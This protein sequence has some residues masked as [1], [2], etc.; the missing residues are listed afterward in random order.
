[1]K[2]LSHGA[3]CEE[4]ISERWRRRVNEREPF[5]FL[6]SSAIWNNVGLNGSKVKACLLL[7]MCL[8]VLPRHRRRF[9]HDVTCNFR[10]DAA[11]LVDVSA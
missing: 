10:L 6:L 5:L 9:L 11:R 1:M 2:K 4:A 7:Y 8:Y 3:Q